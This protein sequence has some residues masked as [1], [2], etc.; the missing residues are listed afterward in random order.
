MKLGS[1]KRTSSASS[2][3]PPGDRGRTVRGA[4]PGLGRLRRV[5]FSKPRPPA[6]IMLA[7]FTL[8]P[9]GTT[10]SI[11]GLLCNS[12][13]K[14]LLEDVVHVTFSTTFASIQFIDGD[15]GGAGTL[16]TLAHRNY[17]SEILPGEYE[18]SISISGNTVTAV[19]ADGL[20]HSYTDPRFGAFWSGRQTYGIMNYA[21]P[22]E[23]RI[24]AASAG[25]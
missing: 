5:R 6:S 24:S 11:I 18:V 21:N 25:Y 15:L 10:S 23:M 17:A 22:K 8:R 16:T 12:A 14:S 2:F 3:R 1:E 9:G 20:S 7:R 13:S 4:R 19:G